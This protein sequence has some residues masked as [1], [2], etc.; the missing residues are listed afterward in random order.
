MP[1]QRTILDVLSD[2]REMVSEVL[3]VIYRTEGKLD[4]LVARVDRIEDR[5][6]ATDKPV[7]GGLLLEIASPR[8]WAIAILVAAL[9][10]WGI[11]TP[12]EVRNK[13]RDLLGLA[14]LSTLARGL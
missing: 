4:S 6:H 9:S 3:R 13:A 7:R 5:E 8:E 14:P 1:L 2:E 10:L 11:V 12:E